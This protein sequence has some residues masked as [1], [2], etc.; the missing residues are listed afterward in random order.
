MDL[1]I[2]RSLKRK[3]CVRPGQ[4][5][6]TGDYDRFG[7]S[8]IMSRRIWF[9]ADPHLTTGILLARRLRPDQSVTSALAD[10]GLSDITPGDRVMSAPKLG[11]GR[12]GLHPSEL[13]FLKGNFPSDYPLVFRWGPSFPIRKYEIPGK[14][15]ARSV[16]G[17]P[18]GA[19]IQVILKYIY[20]G[21]CRAFSTVTTTNVYRGI[22]LSSAGKRFSFF[23]L[24]KTKGKK[25]T[26]P[27]I[28][29]N[30]STLLS[31]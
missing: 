28:R 3:I 19:F 8:C 16:T 22:L 21:S 29:G 17:K 1:E 4:C 20:R 15:P 30:P 25:I 6:T 12:Q 31:R 5:S 26:F 24:G 27:V 2:L 11:P 13:T 10:S 7:Q 18:R 14:T 9:S 23:F